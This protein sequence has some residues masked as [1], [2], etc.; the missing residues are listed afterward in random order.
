MKSNHL[1]ALWKKNRPGIGFWASL[2]SPSIIEAAA[3][4][5]YDWILIDAEHGVSSYNDTP[6]LLR[7]MAGTKATAIVRVPGFEDRS[8]FK[9][10][11]DMGAEG[12]L[13]PQ[14]KTAA[15]VKKIVTACRYPPLG[16]RGFGNARA[17]RYTLD[18]KDY[19]KRAN[20]EILVLVQI[21]TADAL[22]NIDS[23]LKVP[24]LD[25][26][27]IGPSD[28]SSA[29]GCPFEW[30]SPVL[31]KAIDKVLKASKKAKKPLGI[32]CNSPQQAKQRIKEGFLFVNICD[33]ISIVANGL[34]KALKDLKK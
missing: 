31:I 10:V 4:L 29:L 27:L 34:K 28:L 8:V 22:K 9:R 12:V 20:Q 30:N 3:T 13:V 16:D 14:I 17:T 25:G 15:E 1:N 21:E 23:I 7:A 19:S 18:F 11:L 26:A 2:S 33:D 32:F 5:E 6:H 24:G